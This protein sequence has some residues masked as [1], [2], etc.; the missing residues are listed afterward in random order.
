VV[1]PQQSRE[2]SGAMPGELVAGEIAAWTGHVE[3]TRAALAAIQ[4][5]EWDSEAARRMR[6][7]SWRCEV[8]L[9]R[10][11]ASLERVRDAALALESAVWEARIEETQAAA[12]HSGA[13]GDVR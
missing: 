3:R 9:D 10:V 6:E 11:D 5:A 13:L 7:R 12:A 4:G 1:T 2:R 8:S